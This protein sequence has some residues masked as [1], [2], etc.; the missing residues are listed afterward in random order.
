M[1]KFISE[2][3]YLCFKEKLRNIIIMIIIGFIIGF[4]LGIAIGA[5]AFG[6]ILFG[7]LLAG[8][9]YAWSVIPVWAIGWLAIVIKL[10]VAICLGWAI[11][12]ISLIYNLV[13]MKRYEKAVKNNI[14]I[15][16]ELREEDIMREEARTDKIVNAIHT[17]SQNIQDVLKSSK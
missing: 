17:E 16:Q 13:Q 4:A 2:A 12:P 11:T 10:I 7:I 6:G 14:I 9:P 1:T 3:E 5:G 15:E 8:M